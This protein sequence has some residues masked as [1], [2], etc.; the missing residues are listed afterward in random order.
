MFKVF[1]TPKVH[2]ELTFYLSFIFKEIFRLRS[3]LLFWSSSYDEVVL[4]LCRHIHWYQLHNN[5]SF[6]KG[7]KVG[8]EL[9]S[10]LFQLVSFILTF[11]VH[12]TDQERK[13]SWPEKDKTK[14][15]FVQTFCI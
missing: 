12:P 4:V 3:A 1:F 15:P 2:F 10:A 6:M 14:L 7:L 9:G 11:S 5:K 8:A 13:N